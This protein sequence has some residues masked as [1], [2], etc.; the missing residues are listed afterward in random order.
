MQKLRNSLPDLETLTNLEEK[1]PRGKLPPDEGE[2]PWAPG[3][4]GQPRTSGKKQTLP[5]LE[6][7][8][9]NWAPAW[10]SSSPRW[11]NWVPEKL[12]HL[13]TIRK[14]QLGAEV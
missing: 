8:A 2:E 4:R 5:V 10:T 9:S 3:L 1:L 7:Q 13:P 14:I 12:S 11:G 6:P